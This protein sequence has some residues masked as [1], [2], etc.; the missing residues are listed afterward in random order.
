M[1]RTGHDGGD[2]D[3]DDD[4]RMDGWMEGDREEA[5][6]AEETVLVRRRWDEE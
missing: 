5:Q 4:E 1:R 2:G 6:E 3:V